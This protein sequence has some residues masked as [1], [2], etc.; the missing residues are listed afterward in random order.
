MKPSEYAQ[1]IGELPA[2]T[3][4]SHIALLVKR[5]AYVSLVLRRQAAE[6]GDNV[7]VLT[8]HRAEARELAKA[9]LRVAE[10]EVRSDF[11]DEAWFATEGVFLGGPPREEEL[12][13]TVRERR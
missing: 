8:L 2:A 10:S 7:A 1:V 6:D 4:E 5:Y 11:V 12:V 13:E 9:L 3:G